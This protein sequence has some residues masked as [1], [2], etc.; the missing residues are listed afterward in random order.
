MN[1][2]LTTAFTTAVTAIQT[3]V[4]DLLKIAI[5]PA[6]AIFGVGIALSF[7]KRFFSRLAS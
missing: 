4:M 3:D 2:A 7:G 1:E 5:V 6:L